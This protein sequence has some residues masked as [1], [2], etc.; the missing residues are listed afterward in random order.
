MS[1][2]PAVAEEPQK[3]A[4]PSVPVP[5]IP[6]AEAV[7]AAEK[8]A[9]NMHK[10][11]SSQAAPIRQYL[12]SSVVPLLMQGLQALCKERPDNPV[13]YLAMYLL[14]H[15]PQNAQPA[16]TLLAT[17]QVTSAQTAAAEQ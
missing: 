4:V 8:A 6:N 1:S 15:N 11:V 5:S 3:E 7:K 9:L 17:P 2:E 10:K 14:K 16:P 12:E 13:E